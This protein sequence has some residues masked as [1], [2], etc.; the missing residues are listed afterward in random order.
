MANKLPPGWDTPE[1]RRIL[2]VDDAVRAMKNAP[3]YAKASSPY[4]PYADP[5]NMNPR[6]LA[7]TSYDTMPEGMY[8]PRKSSFAAPPLE[9][10]FWLQQAKIGTPS[11]QY[12]DA[13]RYRQAL[14][15]QNYTDMLPEAQRYATGELSTARQEATNALMTG[16]QKLAYQ[17]GSG[18][19]TQAASRASIMGMGELGGQ[20]GG[21]VAG[22]G[23]TERNAAQA[24][25]LQSTGKMREQDLQQRLAEQ[26]WYTAQSQHELGRTG[27]RGKYLDMALQDK[28]SKMRAA[29]EY[30]RLMVQAYKG[31]YIPE[32]SDWQKWAGAGLSAAGTLSGLLGTQGGGAQNESPAAY[33][34]ENINDPFGWND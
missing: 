30:E 6:G 31:E 26:E 29:A 11:S 16:R 21:Q 22:A 28:L 19:P 13:N 4:D 12:V 15:R 9:S 17:Y 32:S 20:V 8:T 14:S 18:A 34:R 3:G 25:Y 33:A 7:P 1:A 10:D 5:N 24:A 2:N 27:L 23:A